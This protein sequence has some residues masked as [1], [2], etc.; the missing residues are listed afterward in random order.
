[1][2]GD[3]NINDQDL[4]Q[5]ARTIEGAL[6]LFTNESVYMDY[7]VDITGYR[8]IGDAYYN[9]RTLRAN[10]IECIQTDTANLQTVGKSFVSLDEEVIE[11]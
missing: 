1:M 4:G 10:V 6:G 9:S 2:T 8:N 5:Q 3:L 7:T 11:G